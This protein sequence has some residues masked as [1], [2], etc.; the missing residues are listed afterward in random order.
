MEKSTKKT[1]KR[2][3]EEP[4]QTGGKGKIKPRWK[5]GESGNP[6]GRPKGKKNFSTLFNEAI[7]KIAKERN[8]KA[9]EI[10]VDLVI[11]AIAEARGG[12]YQYYK[13][14][15]DRKFGKAKESIEMEHKGKVIFLDE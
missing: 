15:F 6:N 1:T 7:E 10:E 4:K 2:R 13:D 3:T 12:N 14:I 5:P 11:R 8:L 9:S